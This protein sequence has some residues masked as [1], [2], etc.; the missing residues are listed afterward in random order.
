M[1]ERCKAIAC[2]NVGR[3]NLPATFYCSQI[4]IDFM[5]ESGY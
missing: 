3:V 1:D 5:S 4:D 2:A